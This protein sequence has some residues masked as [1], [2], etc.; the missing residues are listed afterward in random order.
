MQGEYR[1][2]CS[3][4]A[5]AFQIHA[6][7]GTL[8]V[9]EDFHADHAEIGDALGDSADNLE[10]W[11]AEITVCDR[12][13]HTALRPGD[14]A[15][16]TGP[17]E[18]IVF[19]R[20]KRCILSSEQA[21]RGKRIPQTTTRGQFWNVYHVSE[22][23]DFD[24]HGCENGPWYFE[25]SDYSGGDVFSESFRT[26]GDALQAAREA[27]VLAQQHAASVIEGD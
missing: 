4:T 24:A 11:S 23:G 14:V 12:L 18:T 7:N 9:T 13:M 2:L 16:S 15:Y 8:I 3:M 21:D 5:D 27:D 10:S 19:L 17:T 26:A 22:A 1:K 6:R 20:P 25:P